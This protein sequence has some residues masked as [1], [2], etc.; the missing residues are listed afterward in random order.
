MTFNVSMHLS[1]MSDEESYKRDTF[2]Q[3]DNQHYTKTKTDIVIFSLGFF[4]GLKG[5]NV[6]ENDYANRIT[7]ET[8]RKTPQ[9]IRRHV[10]ALFLLI[11]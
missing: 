2:R 11:R 5:G 10:I 4:D 6:L 8:V 1:E 9:V 7:G 3:P